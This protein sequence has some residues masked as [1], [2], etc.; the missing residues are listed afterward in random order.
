MLHPDSG[1][2]TGGSPSSDGAARSGTAAATPA[3][4]EP[5]DQERPARN[6]WPII[7]AV[8][9]ASLVM[10]ALFAV[11]AP[12]DKLAVFGMLVMVAAAATAAP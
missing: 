9:A 3:P 1:V 4:G 2:H 7:A 5:D 6:F 11:Q 8:L 12:A 10:L